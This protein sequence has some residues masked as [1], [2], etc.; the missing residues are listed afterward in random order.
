MVCSA[1][2]KVLQESGVFPG[3]AVRCSCGRENRV[4]PLEPLRSSRP[5]EGDVYRAASSRVAEAGMVTCPFCGGPCQANARAC[6]HCDVELLSVR[7]PHC[8]ALHFSGARFCVRCG[9]ELELEPLLDATDAPCPRCDKPLSA[10]AGGAREAFERSAVLDL[11]ASASQSSWH[12]CVACGGIFLDSHSLE[13]LI[14]READPARRGLLPAQSPPAQHAADH[15]RYLKCPMCHAFMNRVNFGKRSGVIVDVCR[16]HG[17]WFDAGELTQAIEFV[18]KGGLA[19][20]ALRERADQEARANDPEVARAAAAL[21]AELAREAAEEDHA[22]APPMIDRSRWRGGRHR[23]L[24]DI[25]FELL[26]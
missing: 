18:A 10:A 9:K 3:G 11:G 20:A 24:L 7:C 16:S 8:Y 5:S 13:A 15:V 22:L 12:E 25:L 26:R 23:T 4:P 19:D 14:A 17:T 21:H 6:P 2:G 1:C